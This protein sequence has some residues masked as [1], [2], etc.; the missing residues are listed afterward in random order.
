MQP[1][2]ISVE[3]VSRR[4]RIHA[5]E[6][7]TLKDLFVQRGHTEAVDIW[8]LRD[9]SAD[10]GRDVPECPNVDRLGVPSL[11]EEILERSCL[12]RVDAKA[13]GDALDADL[14]GLH[15]DLD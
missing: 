7:R 11:D 15:R 2:E 13:A 4:F 8:A 10:V 9:V 12:A 3:G 6:A 5:R 1:G 14:A